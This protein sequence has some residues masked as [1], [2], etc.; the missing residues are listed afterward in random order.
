M[1]DKNPIGHGVE[2]SNGRDVRTLRQGLGEQ[3]GDGKG[4]TKDTRGA[5]P[6]SKDLGCFRRSI[7]RGVISYRCCEFKNSLV[8]AGT[9][10]GERM[11]PILRRVEFYFYT[12]VQEWADCGA[13]SVRMSTVY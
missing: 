6:V 5:E 4:D 9:R 10:T 11:T 12:P 13:L 3:G 8:G 7:G 2:G 1:A